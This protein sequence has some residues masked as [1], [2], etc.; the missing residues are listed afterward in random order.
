[1]ESQRPQVIYCADTSSLI[2]IQR[3]YPLVISP[4][5]WERL[6]DLAR[7]GRLVAVR[8]MFNELKR[9]GD[10]E[11][12][13]WAE[14]HRF[15]FRD[16]DNEQVEVVKEVIND[17]RFKGIVDPDKET[18]DA[19]PFV[20]ALAVVEQRRK[21]IFPEQW[22][23]V[24]DESRT[25]PGRKPRIPDI[26]HDPRYQLECIRILDMFQREGWQF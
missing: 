4:R 9:G 13:Q 20:I 3:S 5:L 18:P 7:E 19:D 26:C 1:M 23:V 10:D 12:Y 8:E 22:V 14:G 15:M 6:G 21:P 17:P 16:P 24:A 11:I 2:T 25:Q